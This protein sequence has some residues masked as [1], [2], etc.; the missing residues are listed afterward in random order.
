MKEMQEK[1]GVQIKRWPPEI[2]AAYE[3]AWNE[4]VAEE[5]ARNPSFKRV[6]DSYAK[7]RGN[8]SLWRDYGYL[9]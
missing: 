5:S 8:Y 9:K 6:W 1:G 3:K 4:V 2:I 7:F